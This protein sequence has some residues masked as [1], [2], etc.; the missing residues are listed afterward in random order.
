MHSRFDENVT[1][2]WHHSYHII[3]IFSNIKKN[4]IILEEWLCITEWHFFLLML[5]MYHILLSNF[6]I[7]IIDILFLFYNF[8]YVLLFLT[9]YG[10]IW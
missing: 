9:L 7:L 2:Q 8:I 4:I 3:N 10:F 1:V 5:I 6:V